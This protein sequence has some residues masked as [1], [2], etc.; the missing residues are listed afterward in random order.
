VRV[1]P[2]AAAVQRGAAEEFA[3][4]TAAAVRVRGVATVALSGGS[5]PRGMHALLADPAGP[6]RARVPWAHL[7]VFWGDERCVPPDH[8]DSNYRMARETLLD[9]VP[10]PPE[11]VHRMAG[12]DPEPARAAERYAAELRERFVRQG[13]LDDG[14]PRFDLVLLG[15]GPDGHTASLFPGTEAVHESARAV[16]AVWVPKL[17]A[18]RITLTPPVLTRAETILFLVTGADKAEALA[19]V[20]DG[21]P[22]LDVLPSQTLRPAGSRVLWLVD[23]AAGAR[24]GDRPGE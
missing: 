10:V 2:D 8:P 1:L 13:R 12:D 7:E 16:V 17:E 5:T 20:L 19:S 6:Y 24:L 9:H 14:W 11:R 23:A 21:P 18:H 3:A 4:R 22:R 15:M